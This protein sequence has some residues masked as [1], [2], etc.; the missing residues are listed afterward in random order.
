VLGGDGFRLLHARGTIEKCQ[1][2]VIE[3]LPAPKISTIR[4]RLEMQREQRNELV[5]IGEK[6]KQRLPVPIT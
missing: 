3:I 4:E 6:R 5:R 2:G 1:R